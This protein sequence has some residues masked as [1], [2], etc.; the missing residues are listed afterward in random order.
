MKHKSYFPDDIPGQRA[1]LT[2]YQ[3]EIAVEGPVLGMLPADIL[4]EQNSCKAMIKEIDDTD[5]MLI[6]ASAKVTER[7]ETITAKMGVL[8]PAI[9]IKKNSTLYTEAIGKALELI[10]SEIVVDKLT[11]QTEVSLAK[12]PLG[13]DIKFALKHC[14]GGNIYCKRGK[15]TVF[16]FLKSV[17]HPHTIDTR[18]SVDPTNPEQRSYYT[19]LLINDVEV[20]IPSLPQ[21]IN[22]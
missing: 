11:V 8:R 1:W 21:T 5:A 6:A 19:T 18:P 10:G 3:T 14:Q 2:N 7:D 17:T 12:I 20:G 16:T 9:Q 4:A 22:F 13:V 15:E